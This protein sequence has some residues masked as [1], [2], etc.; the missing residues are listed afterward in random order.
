M[1]VYVRGIIC[2]VKVH[3]RERLRVF[4]IEKVRCVFTHTYDGWRMN[5]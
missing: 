4:F 3:L 2:M 5:E 1:L